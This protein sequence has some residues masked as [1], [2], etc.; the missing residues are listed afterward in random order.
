MIDMRGFA[1]ARH[2]EPELEPWEPQK[3]E[4]YSEAGLWLVLGH[5][6]ALLQCIIHERRYPWR[7]EEVRTQWMAKCNTCLDI[8]FVWHGSKDAAAHDLE[9]HIEDAE[10]FQH[11]TFVLEDIKSHQGHLQ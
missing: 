5:E 1:Q 3:K 10:C 2:D 4:D 7:G 6:V 9:Q 11:A 8:R